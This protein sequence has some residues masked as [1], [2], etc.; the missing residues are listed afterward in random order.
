MPMQLNHHN[1]KVKVILLVL[2][3]ICA[4]FLLGSSQ[5]HSCTVF[6]P[7]IESVSC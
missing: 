2:C 7:C 1:S 4:R 3:L 6:T 5:H